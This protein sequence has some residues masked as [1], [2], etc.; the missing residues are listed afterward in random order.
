LED[1]ARHT[2][3]LGNGCYEL[4]IK[5]PRT[6]EI[7]E[8]D[9]SE[10]DISEL[11]ASELEVSEFQDDDTTVDIPIELGLFGGRPIGIQRQL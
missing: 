6:S 2:A 5:E 4:A 3:A 9:I 8:L 10:L 7:S 11:N 1:E